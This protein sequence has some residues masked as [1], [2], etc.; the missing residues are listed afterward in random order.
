[1]VEEIL[2]DAI[3]LRK[4]LHQHPEVSCKEKNT[5]QYLREKLRECNP[6]ELVEFEQ[7]GLAAIFKGKTTGK[8]ILIRGDFDALPIQEENDFEYRSQ[9]PGV[10]HMCGHDGHAAILY[11]LARSFAENRPEKGD[12]I[13]LFQPAEENGEGAKGVIND[14][15][16]EALNPDHAIALH[17]LPGY[18]LHSV[19]WKVGT[20]TAAA[21][22]III[23]FKGKTS[24]AAEPE[25]GKNP[26][27]AMAELT[28]QFLAQNN[29]DLNDAGFKIATPIYTTMGEKSYGVSA[30]YGELHFTL[31]AWNNDVI[32]QFEK[33]CEELAQE[34][35]RSHGL[36]LDIAWT[37]SFF[38][39]QNN[40]KVIKAVEK[41]AKNSGL[42]T[43]ERKNPFKWG[44]DFGIFTEKFSGAMFGL[45]SGEDYPALHNPDFDFPDE[46]IK[47][48]MTIFYQLISEL[49]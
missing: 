19:I 32:R 23:K 48:G 40:E 41:V 1:M 5:S 31:R 18:P 13:L 25:L 6:D 49:Q 44:E 29:P 38:A 35:A 47:T 20:F 21:N 12:A 27:G 4:H 10:S 46:L 11:A 37:E 17:N 3:T 34:V 28:Q 2:E 24:H 45:G 16:F 15:K 39:N 14:P 8:R 42:E 9:N 7:Y 43:I 36:K 30:G 26:A 22:S 33:T